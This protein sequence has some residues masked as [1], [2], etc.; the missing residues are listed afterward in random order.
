MAGDSAQ[1]WREITFARWHRT[2]VDAHAHLQRA[3]L[4]HDGEQGVPVIGLTKMAA[5]AVLAAR[6]HET[7][8][9]KRSLLAAR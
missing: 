9:P 1:Q 7:L 6:A 3:R 5:V 2:E 4:H 8:I